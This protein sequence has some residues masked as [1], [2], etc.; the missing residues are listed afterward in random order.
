VL[1]SFLIFWKFR[2]PC[3]PYGPEDR[4]ENL[5][6][7]KIEYC[8]VQERAVDRLLD[9]SCLKN[10]SL[11]GSKLPHPFYLLTN[12]PPMRY[13]PSNSRRTLSV[14]DLSETKEAYACHFLNTLIR[15]ND[16][17]EITHL[18]FEKCDIMPF[19]DPTRFPNLET[20]LFLSFAGCR[21]GQFDSEDVNEVRC[22]AQLPHLQ[23][24]NVTGCPM[25][26]EDIS[27]ILEDSPR[28]VHFTFGDDYE[29][30]TREFV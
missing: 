12:L 26:D 23:D 9:R 17:C 16:H 25:T 30:S 3:S 27:Y 14:L 5:R 19:V 20:I 22:W 6:T 24:I 29:E 10:F 21:L 11:R 28:R 1:L 8:T 13:S 18:Y 7:L 4:L 15:E 2:L